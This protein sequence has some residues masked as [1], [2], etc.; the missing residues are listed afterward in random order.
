MPFYMQ[1]IT[2]MPL[3]NLWRGFRSPLSTVSTPVFLLV[4]KLF[5]VHFMFI[6]A[7]KGANNLKNDV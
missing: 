3:T 1:I 5:T 7:E 2:T 4:E 6:E